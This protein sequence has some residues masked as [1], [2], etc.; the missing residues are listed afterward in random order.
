MMINLE[1]NR[2]FTIGTIH[3][4]MLDND[5]VEPN[6]LLVSAYFKHE[7]DAQHPVKWK[8]VRVVLTDANPHSPP[9]IGSLVTHAFKSELNRTTHSVFLIVFSD[10]RTAHLL[11][12]PNG[13]NKSFLSFRIRRYIPACCYFILSFAALMYPSIHFKLQC[14]LIMTAWII[15]TSI[16]LNEINEVNQH[17][18]NSIIPCPDALCSKVERLSSHSKG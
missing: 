2:E 18:C 16:C 13:W 3:T 6:N 8:D 1:G 12:D 17:R 7:K 4:V 9:L 14:A 5:N 15:E 10:D 11:P